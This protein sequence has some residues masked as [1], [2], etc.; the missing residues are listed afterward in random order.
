MTR[1]QASGR[2]GGGTN[3]QEAH[4]GTVLNRT[5]VGSIAICLCCAAITPLL[6]HQLTNGG[7]NKWSETNS[8]LGSK[9][10]PSQDRRAACRWLS[11]RYT[12]GRPAERTAPSALPAS[13][14]TQEPCKPL[15]SEG[16]ST[17]NLSFLEHVPACSF[18]GPN[19]S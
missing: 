16:S 5:L 10:R 19:T 2:S 18:L 9:A 3:G 11:S 7:C 4:L 8:T 12:G 1:L 15:G 17:S 14:G 6:P 13:K